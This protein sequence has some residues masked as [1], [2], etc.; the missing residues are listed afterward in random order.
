MSAVAEKRYPKVEVKR[1]PHRSSLFNICLT[2]DL[3]AI[4][5]A[6]PYLRGKELET[7]V[8]LVVE[9][10]KDAC[11]ESLRQARLKVPGHP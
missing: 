9:M 8:D 7:A 4:N 1:D 5:T 6:R 11:R 2:I 3:E 10:A